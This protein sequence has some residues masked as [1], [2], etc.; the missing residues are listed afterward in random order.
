MINLLIAGHAC[1]EDGLAESTTGRANEFENP[2][3]LEN[4]KPR[5]LLHLSCHL[6]LSRLGFGSDH[7]RPQLSLGNCAKRK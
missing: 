1:R 6:T 2:T 5:T 7:C 4:Q 3:I